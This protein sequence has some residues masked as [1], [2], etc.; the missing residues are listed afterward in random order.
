MIKITY[1]DFIQNIINTRGQF[2]CGNEYH[3]KHHI[4]PKCLGGSNDKSNLIDLFAKEHFIAHKLLAQEHPDNIKLLQAYNIMAFTK[5]DTSQKENRYELTPEEYEEARLL[6]SKGLKEYY[7]DKTNHPCYGTHISEERK[8]K[9]SELHKGNKYC[10]GRILSDETKKKIGDANRNPSAETRAKMSASQKIAQAG[11]KNS[12]AKKVIRLSDGKIYDYG[13]QAA[14]ENNI[15]YS[16]FKS[17]IHKNQGDFMYYEDWLKQ[18][19]N[20]EK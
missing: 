19:N 20:S 2:N 17:R 16:T 4:I 10:L 6:F 14:E 12:R 18:Q 13:K 1:D 3:E 7:K 8:Q 15:N 5:N 9:L 11:A